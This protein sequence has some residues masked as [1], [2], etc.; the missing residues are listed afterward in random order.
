MEKQIYW[1]CLPQPS[2]DRKY[3][4]DIA[5]KESSETEQWPARCQNS[6]IRILITWCFTQRSQPFISLLDRLRTNSEN[7]RSLALT[8]EIDIHK[9]QIRKSIRSFQDS[10]IPQHHHMYFA[11]NL[12]SLKNLE[13][14]RSITLR[15]NS[16]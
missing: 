10:Q 16:N 2:Q 12:H 5:A 3:G 7:A 13:D 15:K 11:I 8:Y 1:F 6:N 14:T 9:T 4:A